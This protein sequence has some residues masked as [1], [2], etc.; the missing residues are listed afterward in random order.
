MFIKILFN[1]YITSVK[2]AGGEKTTET[3]K[4]IPAKVDKSE[5][6]V[7]HMAKVVEVET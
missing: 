1:N 2:A 7:A 6:K 4:G 5:E 3:Q